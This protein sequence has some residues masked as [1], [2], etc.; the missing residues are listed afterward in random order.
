ME[1]IKDVKGRFAREL[2]ELVSDEARDF[3][4]PVFLREAIEW[5]AEARPP[6]ARVE[7]QA[8]SRRMA[9]CS[10]TN[11]GAARIADVLRND[12]ATVLGPEHFVGTLHGFLLRYVLYPFASL[13]GVK[14]G[15]WVREDGW[16]DLAVG[17]DNHK[18]ISIDAFRCDPEGNLVVKERPRT[19]HEPDDE[20]L[21]MVE[22][23]V[24][25]EKR[26]LASGGF[27]SFDDAIWLALKIL[28]RHPMVARAVAGRF[29]EL[30]LDEAAAATFAAR[31]IHDSPGLRDSLDDG[32]RG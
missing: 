12:F 13:V 8:P 9:V 6:A 20:L 5:V 23:A 17:G 18:R 16:P 24:R 4:V 25:G 32:P 22:Q 19:V 15:P 2:A 29:E 3:V 14:A 21:R 28:A 31:G 11:V 7:R 30:L 27:V 26:R 1:A 10:Y